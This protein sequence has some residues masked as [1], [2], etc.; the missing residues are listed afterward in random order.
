MNGWQPIETAPKNGAE[1]LAWDGGLYIACYQ[2][3]RWISQVDA[4]FWE[5]Y[6]N[7]THWQPKLRG[8]ENEE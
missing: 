4:D 6:I 2:D 3:G 7:P 8:P 5:H 1:V